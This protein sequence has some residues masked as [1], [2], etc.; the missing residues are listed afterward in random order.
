MNGRVN[1]NMIISLFLQPLPLNIYS[2]DKT[3]KIKSQC[4]WSK[5]NIIKNEND[6]DL[7]RPTVLKLEK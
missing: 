3:T 1:R 6:R 4:N 2:L 7:N 5:G